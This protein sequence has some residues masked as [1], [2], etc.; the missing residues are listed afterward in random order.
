[1]IFVYEKGECPLVVITKNASSSL[2]YGID[3]KKIITLGDAIFSASAALV[4]DGAYQTLGADSFD[5]T[6]I[7]ARVSAG[8]GTLNVQVGLRF[9]WDTVLGDIDQRTIYLA[10]EQR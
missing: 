2:V 1:M 3:I 5:G 10:I 9:S 8:D 6:I 7:M 4:Q